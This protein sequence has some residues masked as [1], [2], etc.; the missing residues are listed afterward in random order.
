[1]EID[2]GAGANANWGSIDPVKNEGRVSPKGA[3]WG[4]QQS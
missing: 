2:A 3:S 4:A 1:M